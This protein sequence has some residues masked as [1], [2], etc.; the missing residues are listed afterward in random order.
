MKKF[1]IY[2]FSLLLLVSCDNLNWKSSIPDRAVYIDRTLLTEAFELLSV[3]GYKIFN[4]ENKKIT[5]SVGFGGILVFHGYNDEYYAFD[6]ACPYELTQN[7]QVAPNTEGQVVCPVCGS[8]FSIGWGTGA[9]YSGPAKE[10]LRRYQV[11]YISL[12]NGDKIRVI[13]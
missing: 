5:E 10:G 12:A 13:R 11:V 3:G 8:K 1:I 6:L 2:L 9:L 7:I 4:R